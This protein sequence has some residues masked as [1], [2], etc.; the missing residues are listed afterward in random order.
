MLPFRYF[1][2]VLE[3]LSLATAKELD[4]QKMDIT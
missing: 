2:H 1:A 4:A 3:L